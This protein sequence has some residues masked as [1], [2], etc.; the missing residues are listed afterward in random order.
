MQ[1]DWGQKRLGFARAA[2][3]EVPQKTLRVPLVKRELAF[4]EA[5]DSVNMGS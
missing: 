3:A 1:F 4:E 2:Q 5:V